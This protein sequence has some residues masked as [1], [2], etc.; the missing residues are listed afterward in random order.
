MGLTLANLALYLPAVVCFS[1]LGGFLPLLKDLSKKNLSLLL[2]FSGGVLLGAVFLHM[3]PET[4]EVLKNNL[5]WPILAG[6]LLIFVLER[7]VFIHACGES[8]CDFHEIGVPAFVGISFHSLLDG[9][10]L[11]AGYELVNTVDRAI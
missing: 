9:V 10:A 5:G 1:L 11:G 3:I 2:S 4:G 6:F 8:N 7:F